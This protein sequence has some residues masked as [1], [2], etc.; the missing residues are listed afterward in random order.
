MVIKV[1][2][3]KLN[4]IKISNL[5][6]K[7][8]I[9]W[10]I[11]DVNVLVGKN[12]RGKTTILKTIYSLLLCK[13]DKILSLSDSSYLGFDLDGAFIRNNVVLNLKDKETINSL[14]D[15]MLSS[16]ETDDEKNIELDKILEIKKILN[17][18]SKLKEI[19]SKSEKDNSCTYDIGRIEISKKIADKKI[20]VALISTINMSAN[21]INKHI[22]SDGSK[23]TILDMEI[24]SEIKKFVSC[25]CHKKIDNFLSVIN[26]M[27]DDS[28]KK[29][30]INDYDLSA[31]YIKSDK[32]IKIEDLSS[33]ERQLLYILLKVS[34][35]PNEYSVLLMDE[36][37]I[38]L[39]LNWQENL[40]S[41]IKEINNKCQIIIVSHSP[42]IVMN[43]WLNSLVY[44]EDI[45][46]EI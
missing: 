1:N 4:N 33:G 27:Y 31:R 35:L 30:I 21:S 32:P 20:P 23:T 22:A 14:Y 43:G 19:I 10:D 38:S 41:A 11:K 25:N 34:N 16:I 28:D 7:Y 42:A 9:N 24:E 40:I 36:P 29:V 18:F 5:F 26:R 44:F 17:E 6:E 46:K 37:E 13:P 15:S 12:G 3:M 45:A 8:N 39:H 2:I